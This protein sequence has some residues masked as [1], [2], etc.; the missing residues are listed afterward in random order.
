MYS[1]LTLHLIFSVVD[2]STQMKSLSHQWAFPKQIIQVQEHMQ[3][4]VDLYIYSFTDLEFVFCIGRKIPN[5]L[6]ISQ[7]YLTLSV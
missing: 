1:K 4:N 3:R 5:L 6:Q 7:W 2:V